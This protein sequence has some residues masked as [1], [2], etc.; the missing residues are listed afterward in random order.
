[1]NNTLLIWMQF[2]NFMESY[3][4]QQHGL[5]HYK[6]WQMI[7][8]T[9]HQCKQVYG[10]ELNIQQLGYKHETNK[11]FCSGLHKIQTGHEGG[12]TA[13]NKNACQWLLKTNNPAYIS[14][15]FSYQMTMKLR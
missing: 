8:K 11:N 10:C 6:G 7:V 4:S 2:L 3:N 15:E 13:L 9:S 14:F 1:M 5:L 12:L